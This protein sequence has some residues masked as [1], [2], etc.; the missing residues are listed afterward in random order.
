VID[1]AA[2][3]LGRVAPSAAARLMAPRLRDY[4]R[5]PLPPPPAALDNTP[6]VVY[7]LDDNDKYGNCTIV[8][9]ANYHR[10]AAA[11]EGR[12]LAI[13]TA[14][15][16]AYYFSLSGGRDT[17]LVEV[18]VLGA[19]QSRGFPLNGAHKL[20][21]WVRLDVG[22]P[23]GIRSCA[24]LFHAVYVGAELPLAAQQPGTWDA[25]GSRRG[26]A[27][28]GSWG[29]HAMLVPKYDANGPT[30]ITWG[31]QQQATWAWWREYVD[32]AYALLDAERAAAAGV[33]WSALQ[34]D[35][36]ALAA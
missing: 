25:T 32:E 22:D 18:D 27:R 3:R 5:A 35:L 12:Q 6:G 16:D 9:L 20:D 34:A 13:S 29:G 7:G 33:D 36:H 15:V 30:F 23:D 24:S 21:A 1:R 31:A 14:D 8:A 28:P 4:L 10:T 26:D 11:R 17:G 19:A 2:L